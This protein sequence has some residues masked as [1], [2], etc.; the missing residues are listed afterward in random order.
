MATGQIVRK[1]TSQH[2]V[3]GV[4]K[5]QFKS[6]TLPNNKFLTSITHK[7]IEKWQHNGTVRTQL[8]LF[9]L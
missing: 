3:L 6:H 8:S 4:Y 5:K 2:S 1:T 7:T 9:V